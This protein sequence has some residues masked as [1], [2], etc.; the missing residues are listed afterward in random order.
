MLHRSSPEDPSADVAPFS[1]ARVEKLPLVLVD[2]VAPA[3]ASSSAHSFSYRLLSHVSFPSSKTNS[4]R[5][6]DVDSGAT[7]LGAATHKWFYARTRDPADKRGELSSSRSGDVDLQ[8]SDHCLFIY[9]EWNCF[10]DHC[11]RHGDA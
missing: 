10:S 6:A 5:L 9:G 7:Q 11:T 4:R 1:S 8:N 3:P 2:D